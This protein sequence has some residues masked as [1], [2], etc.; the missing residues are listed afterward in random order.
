MALAAALALGLAPAAAAQAAP[1]PRTPIRHVISVMQQDHSF[2]NY[3]GTYPGADGVPRGA[4]MPR[5]LGR[6]ERGCV[7]PFHIGNRA[8]EALGDSPLLARA[9]RDGGAL[10]GFMNA[11]RTR[12]GRD[13]PLVMGHYDDRE[14]PFYWN[15]ADRYVLFDRFFSSATGGTLTNHMFW[16]T[17]G[18]GRTAAPETVPPGGL[19]APTIFDRLQARGISWRFYVRGYNPRVTY[20]SAA[21][22]DPTGQ[23]ASVPLLNY[24]RFVNRRELF[25]HIVPLRRLPEDLRRGT[26][27][28]VSY[29]VPLGAR[30]HPPGSLAVGQSV[31]RTLITELMRSRFWTSSALMLTYDSWGG[32]YDHVPPPRVD[33]WGYGFR[34]PALLVSAW[35]RRGWIDHTT[36]DSAS[37]LRFIETNWRLPSLTA[38]DRRAHGLM[39]AFDFRGAPRAPEFVTD[40]RTRTAAPRLATRPVY[41]TY[42]TALGLG[43]VVIL[44]AL[45]R[46]V[47]LRRRAPRLR[48]A[49]ARVRIGPRGRR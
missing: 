11:L 40:A 33:R 45:G 19:T 48:G 30:E 24:A 42:G 49:S 4:C 31:L 10:D 47:V 14:I 25:R 44:V 37:I 20:R 16:T 23:L 27:P 9:Q 32:W 41:V 6:R 3:F 43:L 8:I 15:L 2:D 35:A 1:A 29:V 36:L 22:G 13:Q 39:Q 18:P 38:R 34:V 28:A 17:G 5:E 21:A 26:L 12:H 7:R 46:E